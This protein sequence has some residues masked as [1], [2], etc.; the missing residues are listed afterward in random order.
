[1]AVTTTTV[2]AGL[3]IASAASSIVGGMQARK[4]G[5]AQAD[6]AREQAGQQAA[7]T[8]RV[9]KREVQLEERDIKATLERQKIAYLASGVSL[10]GSPLLMMEETRQRGAENIE[11]IKKAGEAQSA[12]QIS[13]G[14][15]KADEAK[16]RGRQQLLGGITSG[17]G[18]FASAATTAKGLFSKEV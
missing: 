9:T 18:G 15:L 16:A 1:M 7:E 3:A 11:E 12:A 14:R 17:I 2:L 6:L 5:E 4:A 8:E 13:E 10:E